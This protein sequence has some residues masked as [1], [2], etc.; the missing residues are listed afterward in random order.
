[1]YFT[2]N[3][4][5]DKNLYLTFISNPNKEKLKSINENNKIIFFNPNYILNAFHV[6]MAVNKAFY[7]IKLGRSK[8]KEY[9]KEII[10]CTT[11]YEKLGESL[12]LHDIKNNN[13][14]NYYVIFID[15]DKDELKNKINEL[16]GTEIS[17]DN[18]A[19]FLNFEIISKHFEINEEKEIND[20]DD[21]IQ[22]AIY[23]RIAA[24]EL[25]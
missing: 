1:M 19:H 12:Q 10:H 9:K 14:N 23:N 21:G 22:R 8:S 11:Y 24:K 7:N 3:Y 5:K 2:S 13:E 25:K 20:K 6:M 15:F 18:Y 17:V 16:S 4:A